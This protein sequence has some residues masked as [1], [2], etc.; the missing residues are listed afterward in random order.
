MIEKKLSRTGDYLIESG[1]ITKQQLN[2]VLMQQRQ[3]ADRGERLFI[4]ELILK[5]RFA[6][7]GEIQEAVQKTNVSIQDNLLPVSIMNRYKVIPVGLINKD[8]HVQTPSILSE[9]QKRDILSSIKGYA[10]SL[11]VKPISRNDYLQRIARTQIGRNDSFLK[12]VD[13]IKEGEDWLIGQALEALLVE[14]IEVR[15]SD[16]HI[17]VK[18]EPESFVG[19]RVDS[20]I[21]Q[22][23]LLSESTMR[24]L[25]VRIKTIA[26]MD[27]SN[28]MTEQ[29]G[30][31][32]FGFMGR[33]VDFRVA[34]KPLVDGEHIA[35]RVLDAS[36]LPSIDNLFPN[37]PQMIEYFERVTRQKG[38]HGGLVLITGPTGSGKSTT[39]YALSQRLSRDAFHVVTVEDP[40]EYYLPFASQIQ[41][42]QVL[43]EKA[44]ATEKTILRLDPDFVILGE[45]RDTEFATAATRFA[46][47]GHPVFSTLHAD[48]AG[49]SISRFLDVYKGADSNKDNKAVI[50]YLSLIINQ[51]LIKKLCDCRVVETENPFSLMDEKLISALDEQDK[52]LLKTKKVIAKKPCGC[53]KCKGTGYHGRV[54]M[55][56]TLI[57][58]EDSAKKNE[59]ASLIKDGAKNNHTLSSVD[60]VTFISREK[61]LVKL[62]LAGAIDIELANSYVNN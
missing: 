34:T 40:V 50:E 51:K 56:E 24:A 47:S 3:L 31:V 27:A 53:H 32:P 25:S 16:I 7:I 58:P 29:D 42:N 13:R 41:L 60:G 26:N 22:T 38:K 15:A 2:I 36:S 12:I 10:Q 33:M 62:I 54:L 61:T 1:V 8:L 55:H 39:L 48:S 19:F 44:T 23:Y 6:T 59:L 9:N 17:S 45:L 49:Q 5:N 18:P 14:A 20:E 28:V 30:R 52:T 4:G 57:F 35:M 43:K 37:Q 11:V 21:Q 46:E